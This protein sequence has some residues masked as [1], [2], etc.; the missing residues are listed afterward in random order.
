MAQVAASGHLLRH[1]QVILLGSVHTFGTLDVS[2]AITA[3][4]DSSRS[5]CADDADTSHIR[6][7]ISILLELSWSV[8]LELVLGRDLRALSL[9]SLHAS[10]NSHNGVAHILGRVAELLTTVR[11]R[12]HLARS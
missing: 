3:A 7:I 6:V 1:H 9:D 5:N 10:R 11:G 12:T 8:L 4:L 2:D